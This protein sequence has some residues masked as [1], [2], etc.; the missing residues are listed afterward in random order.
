MTAITATSDLYTHNHREHLDRHERPQH[1]TERPPRDRTTGP[2]PAK[3]MA[4]NFIYSTVNTLRDRYAPVTTTSTF[5]RTGE[6][7]PQEFLEAGDYL[8]SKFRTW[9]WADADSPARRVD[10]LPPGKQYLVTRNVPC[11]RRLDD[12]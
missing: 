5:R 9:N 11:H 2:R 4:V 1:P 10:Y 6:I 8:V 12:D 7:T 3:T